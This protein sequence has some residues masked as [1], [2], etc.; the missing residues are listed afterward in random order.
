[1]MIYLQF[2]YKIKLSIMMISSY[3]MLKDIEM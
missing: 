3:I 2:Q 1:M